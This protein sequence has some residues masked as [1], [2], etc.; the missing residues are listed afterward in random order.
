[1]KSITSRP[2]ITLAGVCLLLGSSGRAAA[3]VVTLSDTVFA[4]SDW[5]L[6]LERSHG[7]GGGGSVSQNLSGGN[8]GA[9]RRMQQSVNASPGSISGVTFFHGCVAK[10]YDPAVSGGVSSVDFYMDAKQFDPPSGSAPGQGV[11]AAIRQ[12]GV[13]YLAGG[14]STQAPTWTSH[15]SVGL[16][17][18]DFTEVTVFANPDFSATGLP[19]EV[20]FVTQV[21]SFFGPAVTTDVGYDNFRFDLWSAPV[22][23]CTAG[24]SFFNCQAQLSATGVA[25]ATAALG[26]SLNASMVEGARDGLYFFGTGGRQANPWGNGS[27]YQ[28]VVPPVKRGGLMAGSGP[29]GSCFGSFSRDLNSLWCPTCPKPGHNPGA[30]AVVQ[31]QLWYRDPQN[32]S[33]QTTSFSDA[34]EFSVAP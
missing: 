28:C 8:P 22:T 27:S 6:T 31:A 19:F 21:S 18:V 24:T 29:P 16:T 15:S 30:G 3:Q 26:F 23:Y 20:G 7:S 13:V 10:T 12:G 4:P 1:M 32:T 11:S 34:I 33:N 9:Y 14:F 25:S 17:E 2:L 5:T